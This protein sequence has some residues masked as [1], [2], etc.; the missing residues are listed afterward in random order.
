VRAHE[1]L[2]FRQTLKNLSKT[3]KSVGTV[4]AKLAMPHPDA[5]S[6]FRSK[7]VLLMYTDPGSGAM[8]WQLLVAAGLGA[9]FYFRHYFSK[10]RELVARKNRSRD[11]N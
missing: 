7:T 11:L 2:T 10:V 6:D 1:H 8:I 4:F 5:Q 3:R 9:A